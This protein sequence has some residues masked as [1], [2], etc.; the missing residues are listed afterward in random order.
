MATVPGSNISGSVSEGV[1]FG[2]WGTANAAKLFYAEHKVP[3]RPGTQTL[4]FW[5]FVGNSSRIST[6]DTGFSRTDNVGASGGN[7][8]AENRHFV[9]PGTS[10]VNG[11]GWA[12]AIS[13]EL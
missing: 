1:I 3:L 8:I 2:G 9:A 12:Y 13:S 4:S 11:Y 7:A 6:W 5:D 10:T